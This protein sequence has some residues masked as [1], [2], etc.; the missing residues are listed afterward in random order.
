MGGVRRRRPT[1]MSLP[2][3]VLVVIA[4]ACS[5]STTTRAGNSNSSANVEAPTALRL[6]YFPNITH[7][8]AIVGVERGI[9]AKH[10]GVDTLRTRTFNAGPEAVEALLGGAIDATYIGPN[11]T[12]NAFVKSK[13]QA[14]RVIS[15][16]TS[17]GAALVVKSEITSPQQLRGKK[18]AS[19]Q[20][21]NTQDVALRYWLAEHGL[22]TDPEGGGDVA[23]L[24][25]ENSQTLEAFKTGA[26]DGAWVPEPWVSRLVQEG[27]GKIL[28]DEASLWP[29]GR[30]VTTHLVVATKFLDEHPQAVRRLLEGQVEANAFVNANPAE[31]QQVVKAALEKV[32][33]KKFSDVLI[34]EAW[35][36]LT[37]TNDPIASSLKTSAQ[38]A[39]AVGLLDLDHVDLDALY[40]LAPLNA[41]LKSRGETVVSDT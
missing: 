4:G 12:I 9:F 13:G 8:T 3:F 5:G 16:T 10:L 40:N 21:G 18:L 24:P 31:A 41:V 27:G 37:F 11:P 29:G 1:L 38:H 30:Y 20:L 28:V 2:V 23:I 17:G 6:G 22:E 14:I 34:H 15:G 19:P 35:K 25:Q 32:T 39:V 7:A 26:I 36:R 33:G